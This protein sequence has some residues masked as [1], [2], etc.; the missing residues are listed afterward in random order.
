MINKNTMGVT[1]MIE[2]GNGA[3]HTTF[4]PMRDQAII[5][6]HNATYMTVIDTNTQQVVTNVEVASSASPE[7]KSQA[8]TSGVSLDMKYFYST[9]SYDGVFFRIDLDT[10]NVDKTYIGGNLLMGSFVWN[11]TGVNM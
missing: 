10:W 11:G 6:N 1:A 9:A 7:Y 8:H 3:G 4:L 5:T 2:T